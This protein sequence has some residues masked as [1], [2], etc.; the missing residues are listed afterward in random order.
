MFRP[1]G[2]SL[3]R[4]WPPNVL[5]TTQVTAVTKDGADARK[6]GT[7]QTYTQD[8]RCIAVPDTRTYNLVPLVEDVEKSRQL[9]TLTADSFAICLS[10]RAR[11][12]AVFR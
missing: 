5:H 4:C 3:E 12:S 2:H 9:V 7:R 8:G 1:D 10:V 11:G 6:N